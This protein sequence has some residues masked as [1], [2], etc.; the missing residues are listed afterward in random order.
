[1]QILEDAGLKDAVTENISTQQP[2]ADA[3]V[4]QMRAGS[5]D[6][7]VVFEANTANVRDDL[8]VVRLD[9][10]L[11]RAT[12]PFAIGRDSDHRYLIQRLFETL[13]SEESRKQFESVGFEWL[14]GPAAE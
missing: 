4:T 7:A 12:Q 14:G 13:N 10:P 1:M 2:T 11:A 9:H 8:E 5:L 6:A 3:L